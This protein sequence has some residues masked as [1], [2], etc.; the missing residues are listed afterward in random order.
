MVWATS[1]KFSIFCREFEHT[2]FEVVGSI[3]EA[4]KG[5]GGRAD[6]EKKNVWELKG[7]K[8]GWTS[9]KVPACVDQRGRIQ[10]DMKTRSQVSKK[11]RIVSALRGQVEDVIQADRVSWFHYETGNLKQL[12]S[13]INIITGNKGLPLCIVSELN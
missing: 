13:D 2:S 10:L 12:N 6:R 11:R 4:R 1:R 7:D 5:G 9:K 3:P 8:K